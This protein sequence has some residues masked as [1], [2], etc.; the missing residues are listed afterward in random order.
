MRILIIGSGGREHALAWKLKQRSDV[1]ELYVAPGNG[2]TA[3]IAVNVPI[4]DGDIPALVAFAREKAVDLV[5]PGPELPLTLGVVDAMKEAGIPC[6]GPVAA[7]ARL[8]G[9]K[10]FAK[11][12]MQAAGVPTAAAGVF[13]TRADAEAF[14]AAHGAPL[15]IKADGLAAGKG[16][17]VAM[18]DEEVRAALDL[19]F[20]NHAFGDAAGT[21]L[22]EEFLK[23]EEVSLLCFCDGK[24][25]LPLPSAQD[26]KAVFDGDKGPNTGGMGAYSPAPI[27]PDEKLDAMAD[28]VTRPILAE[29]ARRGTPFTGIL[30]AGLMMTE[31]GPKVLEY[32]VRFGDPE[33][34]PLLMRLKNDLVD[35]VTACIEGRL[36]TVKLDIEERSAL[37]VVLTAAGYP[38]SYPKGMPI[39]GISSAEELDDV[40]VFQAGT[41]RDGERILSSGGRVLCVTALGKDLRDTQ[42]RAYE[43]LDRLSME[44]SQFRSDIGLKGLKRLGLA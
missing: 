2:G 17:I 15:V 11:E 3:G 44:H 29:M 39:S 8:E 21:V 32:N 22:I 35:V 27:L 13:T 30:Y 18:T 42:K 19:M 1:T 36:D 28:I 33:C 23:G 7:C 4:K 40:Q 25:A 12:V 34:Q 37:G 14:A 31:D 26:H 24:T 43:G 6:F 10:S 5:I 20:E 16:V 41:R 38:G 9:S